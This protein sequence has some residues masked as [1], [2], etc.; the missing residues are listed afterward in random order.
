MTDV[1]W[2]KSVGAAEGLGGATSKGLY[3]AS[4]G[5]GDAIRLHPTVVSL[6]LRRGDRREHQPLWLDPVE[7]RAAAARA[8]ADI[9]AIPE[10]ER[11]P[12]VHAELPS[13]GLAWTSQLLVCTLDKDPVDPPATVT[14]NLMAQGWLFDEELRADQR[15]GIS[16]WPFL[17]V[18]GAAG[19]GRAGPSGDPADAGFGGSLAPTD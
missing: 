19:I 3:L 9:L 18:F 2:G 8:H 16:R 13:A 15:Q 4:Y 14:C 10:E 6:F 5:G 1:V 11:V 17:G 7:V 12:Q